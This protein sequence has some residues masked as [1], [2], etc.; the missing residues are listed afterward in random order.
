MTEAADQFDRLEAQLE[1]MLLIREF[2]ERVSELFEAN[3]I[4][5]FVHLYIGQEAVAAGACS[6]LEDGD[7]ITSTHRGHGHALAKGLDPDRMMAELFAKASGYSGGK[8]GSMH[9][10]AVEKGMLGANG[11]VGAGT[12]LAIGA[13]RSI[14]L[15]DQDKV[16]IS[17]FGEGA[18]AEGMVHEAMNMAAVDDLPV[19]FL[20][21]N[22]GYGEMTAADEQHHVDGF[23]ERGDVYD[24]PSEQLDGMDVEA[25]Y[26][27]TTEAVKRARAGDGP[28]LLICDTYRYHGHYEGDPMVYR[29]DDEV[30]E[31]RERD[32]IERFT[33]RLLD[34]D[35]TSEAVIEELE[36]DVET[37]V[38]EAVE[39]ARES[40]DPDPESAY[41]DVYTEVLK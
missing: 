34:S 28:S 21:E 14:K 31:W 8:G 1:T 12:G 17:F 40:S 36:D 11:I 32:P 13:G 5:G 23:V 27:G 10:A 15:Q 37:V 35:V 25:V 18:M 30:D 6:A 3:E 22:N 7:Y 4:P 39:F 16:C 29:S 33:Q 9:I 26:E 2:E 24:M 41:E 19:I 20:C 38:D